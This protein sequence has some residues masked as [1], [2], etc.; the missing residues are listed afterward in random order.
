MKKCV[1]NAMYLVF[2]C[3]ALAGCGRAK[4]SLSLPNLQVR[5]PLSGTVYTWPTIELEGTTDQKTVLVNGREVTTP[6]GILHY[7]YPLDFGRNDIDVSAGNAVG[8][9]TVRL[10]IT[11]Q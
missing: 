7:V 5:Q 8:T 11:R 3:S 1:I 10:V 9:T 6:D 2:I 4:Q